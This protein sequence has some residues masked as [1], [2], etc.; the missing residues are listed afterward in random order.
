L[1]NLTKADYISSTISENSAELTMEYNTTLDV[2]YTWD[3]TTGLLTQ[4]MVTA[5][6]GLQLIVVHG[7]A[8]LDIGDDLEATKLIISSFPLVDV[9]V[10][11]SVAVFLLSEKFHNQRLR[12]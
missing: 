5:P 9:F 7:E 10:F 3:L 8:Q 1:E 2:Q 12:K 6:S 11:I 4:K